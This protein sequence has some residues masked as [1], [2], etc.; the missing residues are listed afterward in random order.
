MMF[1]CK[2]CGYEIVPG[3]G[4]SPAGTTWRRPGFDMAEL[5]RCGDSSSNYSGHWPT[6]FTRDDIVADLKDI[7]RQLRPVRDEQGEANED[8]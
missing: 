6:S 8:G 1:K 2:W 4:L 3:D 7:E 5:P